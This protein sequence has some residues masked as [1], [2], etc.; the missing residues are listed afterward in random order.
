M[1]N[2]NGNCN[3][4]LML[5][6]SP[7]DPEQ[8]KVVGFLKTLGRKKSLFITK[9]VIYYLENCPNPEIPG[10]ST[11]TAP[12]TTEDIIRKVLMEMVANGQV[13]D[14]LLSIGKNETVKEQAPNKKFADELFEKAAEVNEETEKLAKEIKGKPQK[15]EDEKT[16][17]EETAD[18]LIKKEKVQQSEQISEEKKSETNGSVMSML[19]GLSVFDDED[20]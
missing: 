10:K 1:S 2:K 11:P 5:G 20:F 9:A 3:N 17:V 15:Q 12:S 4:K 19:A 8:L 18:T 7:S 13:P 16:Q 14:T 6:F